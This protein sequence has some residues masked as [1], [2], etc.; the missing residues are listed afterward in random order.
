MT[1]DPISN[2]VEFFVDGV[3]RATGYTGLIL[4]AAPQV[5]RGSGSSCATGY[6]EFR[7]L[8]F[9]LHAPAP[10]G[11]L[12]CDCV[13]TPA[14]VPYF[15]TALTDPG[16]FDELPGAC[17]IERPDANLDGVID[18]RDVTGLVALMID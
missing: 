16:S 17:K 9:E 18:G 10:V 2:S 5:N 12:N 15:V 13:V 8:Q 3:S 7:L 14:D 1:F 4:G 11:D 6:G